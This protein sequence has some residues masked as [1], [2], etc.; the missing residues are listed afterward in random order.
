MWYVIYDIWHVN[1]HRWHARDTGDTKQ[2]TTNEQADGPSNQPIYQQPTNN[3]PTDKPTN[4]QPTNQTTNNQQRA[5][6][7]QVSRTFE[8]KNQ[9]P[10]HQWP[11]GMCG[12]P[13]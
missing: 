13:E 7:Y 2:P 4:Q 8:P 5:N 10:K 6:K 12:A 1:G 9:E 3:Q 11:G